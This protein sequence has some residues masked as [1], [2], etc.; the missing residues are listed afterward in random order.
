MAHAFAKL[1][2]IGLAV[3]LVTRDATLFLVAGWASMKVTMPRYELPPVTM[4]GWRTAAHGE[5]EKS[6]SI[7]SLAHLPFLR[8]C[9]PDLLQSVRQR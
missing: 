5:A 9:T 6:K 3:H 7:R 2:V 4:P 8:C 1:T